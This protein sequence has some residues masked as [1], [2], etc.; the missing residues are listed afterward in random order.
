[1]ASQ[2]W[3]IPTPPTAV[4]ILIISEK[5]KLV[6]SAELSSS[7]F[8]LWQDAKT[9]ILRVSGIFHEDY[10]SIK[11]AI[12]RYSC[13]TAEEKMLNLWMCRLWEECLNSYPFTS[14]CKA[15]WIFQFISKRHCIIAH[16]LQVPKAKS[17]ELMWN[18]GL[19][20]FLPAWADPRNWKISYV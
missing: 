2:A 19:M 7:Y 11:S 9:K 1:M 17:K 3:L 5:Q 8:W 4:K 10:V 18:F 14:W 15:T 16:P 6:N 13:L 20:I 12:I